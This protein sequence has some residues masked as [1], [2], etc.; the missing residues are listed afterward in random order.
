MKIT[1]PTGALD[2]V[3]VPIHQMNIYMSCKFVS[4][5]LHN[6]VAAVKRLKVKKTGFWNKL[7]FVFFILMKYI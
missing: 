7:T 2:T 5:S 4:F 6:Y 1:E 3:L